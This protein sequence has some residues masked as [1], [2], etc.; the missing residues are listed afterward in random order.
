MN[1]NHCSFLE[2]SGKNNQRFSKVSSWKLNLESIFDSNFVTI[3]LS[4]TLL[5]SS[6]NQGSTSMAPQT[7]IIITNLFWIG[8]LCSHMIRFATTK[9]SD[10]L[11]PRLLFFLFGHVYSCTCCWVMFEK[12]WQANSML[13][14]AGSIASILS[15]TLPVIRSIARK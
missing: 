10:F 15:I 12:A 3:Y 6:S 1:Q 4:N 7:T 14:Q 5:P 2:N 11:E 9:T 13:L 8:T